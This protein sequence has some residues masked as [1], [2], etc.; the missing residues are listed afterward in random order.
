MTVQELI[1]KLQTIKDKETLIVTKNG[2]YYDEPNSI[3][4]RKIPSSRCIL[5]TDSLLIKVY[6]IKHVSK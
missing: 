1:N 3:V 4:K 6:I 5:D 2:M